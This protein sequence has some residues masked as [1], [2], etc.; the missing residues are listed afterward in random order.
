VPKQVLHQLQQISTLHKLSDEEV[1]AQLI[2]LAF[3]LG[4]TSIVNLND[5]DYSSRFEVLST[6][7][8]FPNPSV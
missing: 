6:R 5:P 4:I 1:I 7:L 2:Q 8:S 3:E